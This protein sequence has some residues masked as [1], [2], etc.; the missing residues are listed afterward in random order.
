MK[1]SHN[2]ISSKGRGRQLLIMGLTRVDRSLLNL[3]YNT[4]VITMNNNTFPFMLSLLYFK[5]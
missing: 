4:L 2:A 3:Q 5:Y 1:G